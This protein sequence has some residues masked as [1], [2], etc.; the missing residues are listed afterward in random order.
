MENFKVLIVEDEIINAKILQDFLKTKGYNI[1]GIVTKGEDAVDFVKVH[2]PDLILMD[3]ELAGKMNGV[4]AAIKINEQDEIPI[5]YITS[6]TNKDIVDKARETE[7]VGYIIKPFSP[8]QLEITLEMAQ[9][10][11]YADKEIKTYQQYLEHLVVDRTKELLQEVE[12]HKDAKQKSID[13]ELKLKAITTAANDAIVLFNEYGQVKFWNKT[14]ELMFHYEEEEMIDQNIRVLFSSDN[15]NDEFTKALE[16]IQHAIDNRLFSENLELTATRADGI[17]LPV[18]MSLAS[19][20]INKEHLIISVV[21][22]ISQRKRDLEEISRFKLISDL[23]NYGLAI[24]DADGNFLYVNRYFAGLL[25]YEQNMLLGKSFFTITPHLKRSD[26]AN[27]IID[28]SEITGGEGQEIELMNREMK[29]VPVM[30]NSVI[31]KDKY[32]QPRFYAVSAVDIRERKEHE[33]NLLKAKRA[34]EESDRMKTAFLSTISHE[35]RTPLN[36]IIGFSDLI[37]L[38]DVDMEDIKDFNE[39]IH[40]SGNHLLS[41]VEDIL[42]VSLLESKDL[43]INATYFSLNNLMRNVYD[44]FRSNQ[45]YDNENIELLWKGD[46]NDGEDQFFTDNSKLEQIFNK[47]IDNAFKFSERGQIEFGYS[48]SKEGLVDF[49]VKD[50]GKGIH[51]DKLND[52]FESF[53]QADEGNSR[54]HDGLGLGLSIVNQL[55]DLM[56]GEIFVKSKPSKGSIF[57]FNIK[58]NQ[59]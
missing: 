8:I 27:F 29:R 57:S 26:L 32:D 44:H 39:E 9:K 46:R 24:T 21:R 50:E 3:I 34:A 23:A 15:Q 48:H 33:E 37:R 53:K 30:L 52:I 1:I 41:I 19:V 12:M 25:E 36:A 18:E 59:K 6:K 22:D 47:L 11:I 35:L 31:V 5:L 7:P 58:S 49:Y 13:N 16:V 54:A 43:K 14:A 28:A 10:Q 45:R 4:E 55:L 38:T 51:E 56:N 17:E 40:N 2:R 20:D 42:D